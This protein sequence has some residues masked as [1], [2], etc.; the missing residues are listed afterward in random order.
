MNMNSCVSYI[1]KALKPLTKMSFFCDYQ[2]LPTK[3]CPWFHTPLH[4]NHT[5]TNLSTY[6]FRVSQCYLI[7]CLPG[8]GPQ[9]D[10]E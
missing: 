9:Y 1:S 7:D 2:Q 10:T 4:Q 3:M 6:L 8:Y 5:N